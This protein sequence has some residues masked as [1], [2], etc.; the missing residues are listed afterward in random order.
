MVKKKADMRNG[1]YGKTKADMRNVTK[2]KY[3][4]TKADMSNVI[5]KEQIWLNKD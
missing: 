4:K 3:G 5:D 1:K 2:N